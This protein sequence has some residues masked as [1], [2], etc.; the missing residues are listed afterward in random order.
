LSRADILWTRGVLQMQTSALFGANDLVFFEI[1]GVSAL[2][3]D[4]WEGESIFCDF[5]RTSFMDGPLRK[6]LEKQLL[7]CLLYS[8]NFHICRIFLYV[9]VS[10]SMLLNFLE[11]QNTLSKNIIL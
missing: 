2:H 6:F 5:V 4:K 10:F 3:T 8:L 1:Y 11:W 7:D 9:D